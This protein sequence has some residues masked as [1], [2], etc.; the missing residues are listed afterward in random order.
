MPKYIF[1]AIV[2]VWISSCDAQ[3][4]GPGKSANVSAKDIILFATFVC[5]MIIL[6]I[7]IAS[8]CM[9]RLINNACDGG[10]ERKKQLKKNL[11][12][13]ELGNQ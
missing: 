12:D 4:I 3:K 5:L 10:H 2:L 7:L 13:L 11:I 8:G 6:F 1:I 9:D